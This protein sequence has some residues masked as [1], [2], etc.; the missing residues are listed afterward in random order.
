MKITSIKVQAKDKNRVNIEVDGVYRFSL[1]LFQLGDLKLK[2]GQ[3]YSEKEL[4]TLEIESQFGKLYMRAIEYCLMRPHSAKEVRDYLYR[5][6]LSR[7]VKSR[8]TGKVI[9]KSGIS[10]DVTNRV[11]SRLE[12]K[13]YIDD[14]RFASFWVNGRKNSKPISRRKLFSELLQKGVATEIIET[15]LTEYSDDDQESAIKKLILKKRK[16]YG[17]D[18]KLLAY[19]ARQGFRY[20]DI[21][22]ALETHDVI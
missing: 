14:E 16:I 17:D 5:K 3:E 13:G 4:A 6:T 19:L 1:T 15:A 11:F 22:K 9:K 10:E 20:D 7:N 2:V 18:Q 8:K 21:K 12:E